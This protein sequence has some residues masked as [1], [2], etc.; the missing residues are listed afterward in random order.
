MEQQI[1]GGSALAD[2]ER[3]VEGAARHLDTMGHHPRTVAERLRY[4]NAFAAFAGQTPFS[5]AL[6]E[7][8]LTERGITPEARGPSLTSV[9]RQARTSMHLLTEF[10]LHGFF[11]RR[12]AP[13]ES[14]PLP[15]PLDAARAGYEAFC[16]DRLSHRPETL[17]QRRRYVTR[18]LK[19][20][21]LR[22]VAALSEVNPQHISDF[23]AQHAHLK[24]KSVAEVCCALRSF[25]RHAAM[26]GLVATDLLDHVPVVRVPAD[27]RI[28]AVWEREQ[29]ESLLGA[30]DRA[31]PQGKR[32]YAMLL[33]AARLGLRAGDIRGLRLDHLCWD[34]AKIELVQEKT[35]VPLSL[36]LTEEVGTALI[37][38]LRHGRPPAD[39]REV[40]LQQLPPFKPLAGNSA[41]YRIIT[42]YRRRAGIRLP[43]DRAGGT[44]ALRHSLAS[45]LLE[46]GTPLET[47]SNILGHVSP[48]S[49]RVYAKV[50]IE[51]LRS[52]AFDWE[53]SS[54]D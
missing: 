23:V 37:D 14:V 17:K 32:D 33:L 11:Q 36:P 20:L 24:A 27:A 10:H 34:E 7:R 42:V 46:A 40:F 54:D 38:Y 5:T 16:R 35:R 52:V 19:M 3:L 15:G 53:A 21:E 50:G 44:H 31:S 45:R 49:A 30:V 18:F 22:G 12:G 1:T 43:A 25:L 48:D 28:P 8:F 13:P 4:W 6:V 9:Q 26:Q 29:V 41:L 39:H 51:D 47:I 2:V